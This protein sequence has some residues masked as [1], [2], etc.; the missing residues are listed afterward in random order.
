MSRIIQAKQHDENSLNKT[1]TSHLI[2]QQH[3]GIQA[4]PGGVAA[5]NVGHMLVTTWTRR[6]R[7]MT[8]SGM[9]SRGGS[10][11][12][13]GRQGTL[14]RRNH[15]PLPQSSRACPMTSSM[16]SIRDPPRAN[17]VKRTT[18]LPPK[19]AA[20]GDVQMNKNLARLKSFSSGHCLVTRPPSL[21]LNATS[22]L[23][24]LAPSSSF[25]LPAETAS[26]QQRR[27]RTAASWQSFLPARQIEVEP[28][29]LDVIPITTRM[30]WVLQFNSPVSP[31]HARH[32]PSQRHDTRACP[33]REDVVRLLRNKL[34]LDPHTDRVH[35]AHERF[36]LGTDGDRAVPKDTRVRACDDARVPRS[37]ANATLLRDIAKTHA[38]PS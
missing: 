4:P 6:V 25:L 27:R 37:G 35:N 2:P 14:Q 10:P 5:S 22:S 24:N 23:R 16:P 18:S 1:K 29:I 33:D 9:T 3:P 7:R 15:F 30:P 20:E 36:R 8:L 34:D 26:P 11:L 19:H 13:A 38:V 17:I 28:L 12:C 21:I 31:Q 32:P